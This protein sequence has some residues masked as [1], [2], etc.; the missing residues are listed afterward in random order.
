MTLTEMADCL[1][2]AA[3]SQQVEI[4]KATAMVYHDQLGH[5][6]AKDLATAVREWVR[7]YE[8]PYR[9]L[10]TVGEL[11]AIMRS[12]R[13]IVSDDELRE[14]LIGRKVSEARRLGWAQERID[15]M[16]E[17]LRGL[18]VHGHIENANH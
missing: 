11:R 8:E 17:K 1:A 3:T 6:S 14:R 4:T 2:Y 9:R 18:P 13:A 12:G 5:V 10:P 15:A 16:I 7:T